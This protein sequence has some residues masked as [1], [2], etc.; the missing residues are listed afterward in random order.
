M[1][2][3]S[4]VLGGSPGGARR[5]SRSAALLLR[6]PGRPAAAR[7]SQTSRHLCCSSA[8][9]GQTEKTAWPR[10]QFSKAAPLR[11]RIFPIRRLKLGGRAWERA[12]EPRCAVLCCSEATPLDDSASDV[13]SRRFGSHLLG[14]V[15]NEAPDFIWRGRSGS[16]DQRVCHA[17]CRLLGRHSYSC[18]SSGWNTSRAVQA[19]L[20]GLIERKQEV[21]YSRVVV[22]WAMEG[23]ARCVE[24]VE[25]CADHSTSR[26]EIC[27]G[28]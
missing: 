11:R 8:A 21:L 12:W 3:E 9:V 5:R 1:H 2:Q 16:L 28:V 18:G 24:S 26:A 13:Y 17:P 4:R 7:C 14:V 15:H 19:V 22:K 10:V 27:I 6:L 25:M 20:Q 23:V